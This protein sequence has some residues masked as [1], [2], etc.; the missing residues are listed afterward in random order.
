[1]YIQGITIVF[2]IWTIWD[3]AVLYRKVKKDKSELEKEIGA[4]KQE[5]DFM[6]HSCSAL[7]QDFN[8]SQED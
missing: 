7:G 3:Y 2:L 1:M 4:L 6:K 8:L 5:V